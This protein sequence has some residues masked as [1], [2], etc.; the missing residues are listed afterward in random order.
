MPSSSQK[1]SG[2]PSGFGEPGDQALHLRGLR[3]PPP[4]RAA[5]GPPHHQRPTQPSFFVDW[6]PGVTAGDIGKL[7]GQIGAQLAAVDHKEGDQIIGVAFLQRNDLAALEPDLH[8]PG[9]LSSPILQVGDLFD[10]VH[11]IVAQ[12]AAHGI[13]LEDGTAVRADDM[14]DL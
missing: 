11:A 14:G 3:R 10:I 2:R 1:P 13:E 5:P 7:V 4:S 8:L 6:S 9:P 12:K